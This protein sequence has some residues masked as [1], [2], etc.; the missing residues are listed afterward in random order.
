MQVN[1]ILILGR[2]H[3]ENLVIH[4]IHG[5]SRHLHTNLIPVFSLSLLS[6]IMTLT[7]IYVS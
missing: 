5:G 6:I 2:Q 3:N 1:D 4:T 7:I